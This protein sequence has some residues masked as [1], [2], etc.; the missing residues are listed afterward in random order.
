LRERP[1]HLGWLDRRREVTTADPLLLELASSRER[2]LD[3]VA[4]LRPELHRFCARMTGSVA[5]GED[6]VQETL[7]RAYAS[8]SQLE[9]VA[10]LRSWLFRIAHNQAIDQMRGYARRMREPLDAI[11]SD[12]WVD[13]ALAVDDRLARDEAVHA[14]L[15]R[16][17]ELPRTSSNIRSWRSP[18]CSR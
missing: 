11:G 6:V 12:D 15:G 14:A 17:I 3:A 7:T 5:D 1:H 18:S 10:Q 9:K 8:L 16:F 4:G 2:F 13:D